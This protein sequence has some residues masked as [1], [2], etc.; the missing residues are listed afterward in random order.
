MAQVTIGGI[1]YEV[2]EMNFAA[3]ERAWPFVEESMTTL[4]PMKGPSAGI[5][6]IAAGLMEADHFDK[7]KFGI[8][9]EEMLGEDQIF[10]RIVRFLK[11]K[12]KAKEIDQV[13]RAVDQINKEAGLEPE[14]GEAQPALPGTQETPSGETAQ[15]LSQNSS[16]Q[17]A[18][19]EVGS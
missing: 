17:D 4:D 14:M 9:E 5:S 6:I 7:T 15:I 3:L 11:K 8:G 18:R 12:L 13:R 2:P 19:E 16:Q 1:D 10:E